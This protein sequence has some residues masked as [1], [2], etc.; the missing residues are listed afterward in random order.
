M[1]QTSFYPSFADKGSAV[2]LNEVLKAIKDGT[3][4]SQ[5]ETLRSFKGDE[6]KCHELKR[7]LPFFTPSAVFGDARRI[8]HL[9]QYNPLIVLDIDKVGVQD[10]IRLRN[11]ASGIPFTMAAFISPGNEGVKILVSVVSTVETHEAVFNTIAGYY[12]NQLGIEIDRSGKDVPRCCFVSHDPD[13]YLNENAQVFTPLIVQTRHCLV[14]KS[15]PD[16]V[17]KQVHDYSPSAVEMDS[18]KL[19]EDTVRFTENLKGYYKG[20]RN[21]FLYQLARN[22]NKNGMDEATAERLISQNYPDLSRE[23]GRIV[24]SAYRISVPGTSTAKMQ[25]DKDD[26]ASV[27]TP[28]IPGVVY[29]HLPELLKVSSAVFDIP[30]EKDVYLTGAL[31]ILSGCFNNVVGIYSKTEYTANI[32]SF[33]IAPPASG[34]GVLNYS[35]RLADGVH[36]RIQEDYKL[37]SKKKDQLMRSHFIPG[38]SSAAAIKKLLNQNYGQ[39]TIC[40]TEADTM[41]NAL[42]QDWGNFS[43]LLRKSFHHEPVSCNRVSNNPEEYDDVTISE[44]KK[45]RLSICL[46]GTPGQVSGLL[47]STENGLFSRFL[48][49]TYRNEGE[50]EFRDVFAKD[51]IANLDN[52]FKELSESV[53]DMY[54]EVTETGMILFSLS[55]GQQT[56]FI[57]QFDENLKRLN[58]EFGDETRGIV[59]RLGLITFR[60]AMLL[61]IL[62]RIEE[63]TLDREIECTD[64]DFETAMILSDIY[65][66]HSMSVLQAMPGSKRINPN[67]VTLLD[68]LPQEFT[69]T[70]AV[71]SGT[72]VFGFS[73]RSVAYYLNELLRKQYLIKTGANGPYVKA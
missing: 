12:E 51:G 47:S 48:F 23:I 3:F 61:T 4:S 57:R 27:K 59:H 25:T 72:T 70:E 60:I 64:R 20:N 17:S 8:E 24:K 50:P 9:V 11:A 71:T 46:S 37:W 53:L 28:L 42:Q 21:N 40:E 68:H 56:R 33:V 41:T 49:Y 65:L 55:S 36:D 15:V 6:E 63:N 31:T 13:L 18:E 7:R 39:G 14:S 16:L 38:D 29:D 10:A 19:F 44:I 22:L 58:R 34:K 26:Y 32:F 43:D 67:A 66:E 52:Y 30:R 54:D 1:V 2:E 62:R 35:R 5:I 69:F 45:P 73:E